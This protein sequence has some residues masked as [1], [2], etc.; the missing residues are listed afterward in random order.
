[1]ARLPVSG[2][3]SGTWGQLLNDFLAISHKSDG[4]LKDDIVTSDQLAPGSVTSGALATDAV[5]NNALAD[6]SVKAPTIGATT[7]PGTGD[8]LSYNGTNLSWVVPAAGTTT[9][10][11]TTST[12]GV[13]MLGGDLNGT[14]S[15]AAAP[16]ITDGAITNAKISASAGIVA[17]KLATAVQT[18][19]GKADTAVQP[20][21][22]TG[23]ADDTAVV[24]KAGAET[25]T[26]TKD[27]TG[28]ITSS[29]VA[30]VT[31]ADAR[32]SDQRVPT[33]NSVSNVKLQTNAVTAVKITDGTIS[34][35][36]LDSSVQ[37]KLNNVGGT[38][39][40][41]SITTLKLADGAVT[42][43][44]VSASAA[45][46]QSKI[47]GLTT[48]LSGK[49]VSASN[50]SD[51][52]NASTARTNLGLGTAAVMS[53]AQLASDSA[54]TG[55]YATISTT[56]GINNRLVTVESTLSGPL[57][58]SLMPAGSTLT[59]FKS[60]GTWPARPTARTD[61]IVRWRGADPSP[62]IVSSGTGGMLDN[63]DERQ[64]PAV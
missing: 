30:L 39:A 49:L 4:I 15:S 46:A 36:K 45:I 56:T 53:V 7:A 50:L 27:F 6:G 9:P 28:G 42:D 24:H 25:I 35:A 62:A 54:F 16:V 13:I 18:S 48:S 63:V 32:L 47:S 3:D 1:M 17:S 8:I 58:I 22:I 10:D 29:G 44:K 2:Q 51:L 21:G 61:I 60:G 5:G 23:K 20:A 11:A 55:T 57:P 52:A 14:A 31:T 19:L 43:V 40:D 64:I 41:G 59:V 12:K 34:E 37:T 33:D 38:V 26:G